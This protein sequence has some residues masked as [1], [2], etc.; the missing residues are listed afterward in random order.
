MSEGSGFKKGVFHD[1][2]MLKAPHLETLIEWQLASEGLSLSSM[3]P[4]P[5]S[6]KYSF[7]GMI[8]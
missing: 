1:V 5:L 2:L 6:F 8:C 7:L 4:P 3:P